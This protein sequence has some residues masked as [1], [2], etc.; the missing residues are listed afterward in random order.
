MAERGHHIDLISSHCAERVV[1]V[2]LAAI[3][4]ADTIAIPAEVGR[5]NVESSGQGFGDLVPAG[6]R[7]RVAMEQQERRA[8]AAVPKEDV[9]AIGAN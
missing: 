8:L 9:R 4:G 6:K 1:D 5:Y 2:F 3:R 7:L